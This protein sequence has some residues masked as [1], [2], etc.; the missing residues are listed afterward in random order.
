[1]PCPS[2]TAAGPAAP[3]WTVSAGCAAAMNSAP[4]VAT[5]V[6]EGSVTSSPGA[7]TR[8]VTP[9]ARSPAASSRTPRRPSRP[10]SRALVNPEARV[11]HAMNVVCRPAC[12]RVMPSSSA[13]SGSPGTKL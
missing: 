5:T 13:S 10:T 8:A 12:A 6:A 4:P 1:M 7:L 11:P 9:T 3:W 2:L